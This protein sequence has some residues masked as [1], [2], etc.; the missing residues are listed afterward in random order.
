MTGFIKL[1]TCRLVFFSIFML[2]SNFVLAQTSA[3]K[4][5]TLPPA[6]MCETHTRAVETSYGLPA[7][8]LTAIARV[9][10]GRIQQ[11]GSLRAW[12]WTIN[13]DG[14]G[15]FFDS[16]EK[17]L[18]FARQRQEVGDLKLDIGCMQINMFWHAAKF[19]SLAVMAEPVANI[20]YAAKFI[21]ELKQRHGSYEKAIA[22]YH[23]AEPA[24][25]VPYLTKVIATWKLIQGDDNAA[26][27]D[28][29]VASLPATASANPVRVAARS[30]VAVPAILPARKPSRQ[31]VATPPSAS[32][33]TA[34][35]KLKARQP[36]LKGRWAH[37]MR[38]RQLLT[39]AAPVRQ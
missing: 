19:D 25:N 16:Y 17:M 26:N 28:A 14:K 10:T 34:L 24:K 31:T 39:P 18:A 6:K 13:H 3:V 11:D 21:S 5:L 15:L 37:V 29:A 22:H 9:E 7:G 2:L 33:E 36:H 12:P 8:L 23:S 27:D 35:A 20:S 38:F 32:A 30:P 1:F 4:P